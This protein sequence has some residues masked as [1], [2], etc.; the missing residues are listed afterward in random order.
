MNL[1]SKLSS[2]SKAGK[3]IKCGLIGG[4]KFGSMLLSQVQRIPAIHIVGI[5]DLDLVSLKN[6][7]RNIGWN[8]EKYNAKDLKDAVQ[9]EKTYLTSNSEELIN[10]SKIEIIIEATGDPLSA[11][12]HIIKSFNNKKNVINVTVEADAFCGVGLAKRAEKNNL[13]YSMAFGDQPAL[14]CDLVDWGRTC[15]FNVIAAGRGHKWLPHY[16]FSTPETVWDFWGLT[17]KQ[18]ERG[19]L[20]PK[21]FNSFLDGS[22][23]A[24]ESAAIANSTNLD[25]PKNGLVFP[26]GSIDEIPNLMRPKSLGGILEKRGMVE[27][28]SSLNKNGKQIDYDIRKGVWVCVEAH[29]DYVKNCFEEYKLTTDDTGKFFCLYKRWHLI[30]LEL[31]VSI[32]NVGVRKEPTG[33]SNFFN[34]DV[35]AIS[36]SDFE[37][38]TILDGEGGK[39]IYGGLRK[40]KDS[41]AQNFLPLGLAKDVKLKRPIKKDQ[42]IK[43]DDVEINKNSLAFLIRKETENLLQLK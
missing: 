9:N 42:I 28:I 35:V 26:S 1:Y 14:V 18:A 19:K 20:N 11:V 8:R 32:A 31:A 6:N 2:L 3:S 36:K 13:I 23:P 33:V 12:N 27:V 24:I 43:F 7:M 21:M 25:V 22:K 4:G 30:G 29:N 37:R 17:K 38:E 41:I 15:G 16:R 40:S 10:N 39:T 5:A 34:A